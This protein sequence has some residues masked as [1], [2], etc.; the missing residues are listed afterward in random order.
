M[1]TLVMSQDFPGERLKKLREELRLSLR[2]AA[3]RSEGGITHSHIAHLEN[4]PAAW[5]KASYEKLKALARAYNMPL[6]RFLNRINGTPYPEKPNIYTDEAHLER[7]ITYGSRQ[8]PEYDMLQAGPG[9]RGGQ[10]IGHIDYP[11]DAP[12]EYIAYRISG[13]SMSPRISDGD[14][15]VIRVRDYS[16]PNNTIVCWTPEDGMM[17]KYLKEIMPD[18]THVLTS[19]NP[20]YP[21]IWARDIRIYGLVVQIRQNVAVINGNH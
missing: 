19:H 12:G 17:C 8:I 21:P 11:V 20:E 10:V 13:D 2:E 18:G 5:S 7:D 15:V 9:G 14:T 4:D 6:E 1:L 16:S 3:K